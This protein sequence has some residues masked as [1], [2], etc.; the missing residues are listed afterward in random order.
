MFG[1]PT[2]VRITGHPPFLSRDAS[3]LMN[4]TCRG[5]RKPAVSTACQVAQTIHPL[6]ERANTP[7]WRGVGTR[8]L[9]RDIGPLCIEREGSAVGFQ[10][11]QSLI[12]NR[13]RPCRVRSRM[14]GQRCRTRSSPPPRQ[15]Q[16]SR[17]NSRRSA[18]CQTATAK[19]SQHG[20][21]SQK[22]V[23]PSQ[24]SGSRKAAYREESQPYNSSILS[25]IGL[26]GRGVARPSSSVF[27]ALE[28]Q[29]RYGPG[30]CQP[31]KYL[32]SSTFKGL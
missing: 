4:L 31:P 7:P 12:T 21:S 30:A 17:G 23:R 27:I 24:R 29:A 25:Y 26:V 11:L 19:P 15:R 8:K 3:Q 28:G 6:Q 14:L 13:P 10:F 1:I 5:P 20:R 2:V 22:S 18:R 16:I 9:H 32:A